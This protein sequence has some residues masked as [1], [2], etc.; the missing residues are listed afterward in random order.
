MTPARSKESVEDALQQFIEFGALLDRRTRR[1]LVAYL[2]SRLLGGAPPEEE[3]D[4]D[5]IYGRYFSRALEQIFSNNELVRICSEQAALG[6]Q[7]TMETLRWMRRSFRDA[8]NQEDPSIADEVRRLESTAGMALDRFI[9]RWRLTT[10]YLQHRYEPHQLDARFYEDGFARHIARRERADIPQ[11][12]RDRVELLLR[13]LLASWDAQLSARRLQAQM[14]W[15]ADSQEAYQAQLYRKVDE[16][17]RLSEMLEPFT[18]YIGR[19]WDMSRELWEEADLSILEAY[20]ELLQGEDAIRELA[21]LL[22][23]MREAEILTEEEELQRIIVR[24]EWIPDPTRRAQIV[25]VHESDELSHML[26][27][28]A[29]LLSEPETEDLFLKKYAEKQLL[30]FRYADRRLIRST[31][32]TVAVDQVVQQRE[33]GPFIL[34]VDTSYSMSGRAEQ[35]AKVLAFAIL[36]IAAEEGRAAYLI[37]FS[38]GIRTID[39]LEVGASLGAIVSFLKMSFHGGTDITPALSEALRKL[40]EDRYKD[41]DVL[42][43]SDFIMYRIHD[44]LLDAIRHHQHN[45][46]TRFHSLTLSES[47]NEEILARFDTNWLYDPERASVVRELSAQVQHIRGYPQRDR[48]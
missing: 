10:D 38:V 30:T 14:D 15:L 12:D 43:V 31:D 42:V 24:Q 48:T 8:R 20:A 1:Y 41:A 33:R 11:A 2:R 36:R 29:A 27:S 21:D 44:G 13:D 45:H 18:D 3:A 32:Q 5:E 22:G 40:K 7:V 37:N 47:A 35:I 46:D 23:R 34:C 17:R 26:S 25:G 16:F 6:R 9:Q 28:E 4:L 19:Y 39:L